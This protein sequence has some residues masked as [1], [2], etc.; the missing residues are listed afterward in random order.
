[1]NIF[2]VPNMKLSI[3]EFRLLSLEGVQVRLHGLGPFNWLG[4][5]VVMDLVQQNVTDRKWISD[6]LFEA[7]FKLN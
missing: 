1:M 2:P 4:K 5:K 6:M 7:S 3:S